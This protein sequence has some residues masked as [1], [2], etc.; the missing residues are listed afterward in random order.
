METKQYHEGQVVQTPALDRLRVIVAEKRPALDALIKSHGHLTVADYTAELLS[1][2]S[3]ETIDRQEDFTEVACG[4]AA[5]VYGNE[6]A[7]ALKKRLQTSQVIN[8]GPHDGVDTCSLTDQGKRFS[9][10]GESQPKDGTRTITVVMPCGGVPMNNFS[11]PMGITVDDAHK[12]NVYTNSAKD[13]SVHAAPAFT[14]QM[15]ADARFSIAPASPDRRGKG[16]T[17]KVEL[18]EGDR[19]VVDALLSGLY[20]RPHVLNQHWYVDQAAIINRELWDLTFTPEARQKVPQL[21]SLE[22]ETVTIGLLEK[23]LTNPHSFISTIL[24]DT[25]TRN[26][27]I[28]HLEGIPGCWRN[29]GFFETRKQAD[30]EITVAH[31][32]LA[33]LANPDLP[34]SP[35]QRREDA[36]RAMTHFFWGLDE[37]GKSYPLALVENQG[38]TVLRRV[39]K[40]GVTQDLP[41]TKDAILAGLRNRTLMPSLVVTFGVIQFAR[42][43]NCLGGFMQEEYLTNMGRG[44]Q[45]AFEQTNK[46]SWAQRVSEAKRPGYA[47]GMPLVI[48]RDFSTGNLRMANPID[49][50]KHGGLSAEELNQLQH[51]PLET[52]YLM[53]LPSIARVI[54]G[55]NLDKELLDQ[56]QQEVATLWQAFLVEI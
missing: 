33:E 7:Q 34:L 19:A 32:G 9:A 18:P 53:G 37:K 5:R 30:G 6:T 20:D 13:T 24:F 41:F 49:M 21:V 31:A 23:D 28:A 14:A 48:T 12:V 52:E 16:G 2:P 22:Q 26:A 8:T 4:Y 10:L 25:P 29:N 11:K 46:H 15:V 55:N 3:V 40:L 50:I 54:F 38:Q 51:L 17:V 42:G 27:V 45:Q 36:E 39:D 35:A 1:P 47:V 56:A 43:I 44:F